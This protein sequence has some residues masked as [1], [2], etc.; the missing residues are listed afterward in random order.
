[1][2]LHTL[3]PAEVLKRLDSSYEGLSEAVA[4]RRLEEFG[5]NRIVTRPPRNWFKAY[6]NQYLQF[7]ALLLEVASG[8]AFIAHVYEPGQGND[9]LAWAILGAVVVNASFSFWQEYRADKAM[10]AL[11]RLMPAHNVLIRGGR[12]MRI[13]AE[14]IVPGD[15][16]VLAEGDRIPADAI[17][18]EA[19]S[20]YVNLSTLNGE[21]APVR[22]QA[23]PDAAERE[24]DAHNLVF[25]GTTVV[26]G[27][28]RAVVF[29][30]GATTEF[31]KIATLTRDVQKTLSPMQREIITITRILTLIAFSMGLLFLVLGLLSG[32]GWLTAAVFAISLIV[33]NVPEGLLPT[34]TLALSMA[35]QRM[36]RRQALVKN[37]D[38]VETLGSATVICTDKTGTLTRNEMTVRYFWLAGGETITLSG[39][40]YFEPGS[41]QADAPQ[42]DTLERLQIL[43]IAAVLNSHARIEAGTGSGRSH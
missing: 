40:G 39:E 24:L 17:L 5:P 16:L 6:L 29:A 28:G 21:S 18:L 43:V 1:M 32:K 23:L 42:A 41:W 31:G 19:H 33:A 7:F 20:L 14:R 3:P 13:E 26:S 27:S 9:V 37:L 34:I 22:R 25:A 12:E 38:S 10:E 2:K 8:L 36:A 15:V 30:T 11:L 35:S 4:Q